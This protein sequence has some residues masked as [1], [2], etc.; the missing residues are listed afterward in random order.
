MY[1]EQ[2][3]SHW[4]P[5]TQAAKCTNPSHSHLTFAVHRHR[6]RIT[7]PDGTVVAVASFDPTSPYEREVPPAFG[8]YFDPIWH[9]PWPYE[10]V[11]WPD[12]GIPD[13]EPPR[14]GLHRLLTQARSEAVELG[15][16]GGHGRTG[17]ALAV[18]AV[19]AGCAADE[20]VTWVRAVYC[21]MA[22]ETPEQ[23]AFVAST[24][25]PAGA[26]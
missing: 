17:T 1:C 9:P 20:A 12:F 8:L 15:C 24:A 3:R 4:Y 21:P 2:C 22:V 5:P 25:P 10:L 26:L 18:L 6:D 19:L 11:D 13:A 14:D 7:L 16:M 23:E